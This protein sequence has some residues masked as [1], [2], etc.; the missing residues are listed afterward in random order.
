LFIFIVTNGLLVDDWF[1]LV[2][3]A[4]VAGLLSLWS[5]GGHRRRVEKYARALLKEGKNKGILG[6]HELEITRDGIEV[7]GE[8]GTGRFDW[9]AVERVGFTSDYTFIFTSAADGI[10]I[11]KSKV[12][13]GDYEAVAQTLKESVQSKAE[14]GDETDLRR[15]VVV[16]QGPILREDR[17]FGKH[18]GWGL[19]SFIIGVT[20]I[21]IDLSLIIIAAILGIIDPT[22]LDKESILA[23]GAAIVIILGLPAAVAGLCFGAAGVF[24]R[25]R[26]KLFSTLGLVINGLI[27]AGFTLLFILVQEMP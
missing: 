1:S 3:G 25:N 26:K 8:Y 16:E 14:A 11:P 19:S 12:L 4:V 27:L 23:Q 9:A 10:T 21:G 18:S 5:L 24:Q 7:S 17:G 6:E 2:Y 13:E 15:S 22:L 20:I